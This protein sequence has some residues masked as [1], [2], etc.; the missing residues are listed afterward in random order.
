MRGPTEIDI[1]ELWLINYVFVPTFFLFH[2][3]MYTLELFRVKIISSLQIL[4]LHG[5]TLVLFKDRSVQR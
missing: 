2:I 5:L 1:F 4:K 3:L